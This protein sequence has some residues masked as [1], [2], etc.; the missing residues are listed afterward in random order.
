MPGIRIIRLPEKIIE[1]K[2]NPTGDHNRNHLI[3]QVPQ[4]HLP[5][6]IIP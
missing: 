3:E 2:Y 5:E 4:A 6:R 1:V